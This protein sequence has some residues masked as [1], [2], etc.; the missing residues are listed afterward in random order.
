MNPRNPIY[1][2]SKGRPNNGL[3]TRALDEMGVP[4]FMV[5]EP[6]EADLYRS[7]RCHGEILELPRSYQNQYETLD[8]WGFTKSTGPGPAR[9]FCLDHSRSLGASSH[10]VM[11]D[12]LDA[13]HRLNRN[14][15]H[16]VRTGATL[17][18]MED[19]VGR[20]TNVPIAG[21]NYYSFA[22]KTDALSPFILNT[23][24][25]SCLLV[26]NE[27]G[28]RWRGRY[29]EDTDLSLRVLKAGLCTIQFNAFLC[30][31][32]TTQRMR[33][34]NS[35]DFYDVEG[36]KPK[37]EMLAKMHPDV[38]KVVWRFGR[39]HHQ[40]NYK[41]FKKNKLIPRE[42]FSFLGGVNNYGMRLEAI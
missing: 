13:F 28:F 38:T 22:K 34:G 2:V 12:N 42:R 7:G 5:V 19:F 16:E 26:S 33:G 25:Y 23:R 3:T 40:V 1:I 10:W 36:T 37:S 29:N 41:Q 31:K 32:I 24:I 30:G 8:D 18:A 21:P 35:T 39:W 4:H 6:Q 20:F 27:I 15:K 9:N 17:R 11:D 14:E